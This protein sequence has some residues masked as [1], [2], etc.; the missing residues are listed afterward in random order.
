MFFG[1]AHVAL[2]DAQ[3]TTFAGAGDPRRGGVTVTV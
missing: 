2:T 1:G 3:H